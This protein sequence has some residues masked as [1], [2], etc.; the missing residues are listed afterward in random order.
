M[1]TDT[2]LSTLAS[3]SPFINSIQHTTRQFL[4]DLTGT[5][6]EV[7]DYSWAL[8]SL[9][10]REGELGLTD[11]RL[12]AL[13]ALLCPVLQAIR[14]AHL[15]F[16]IRNLQCVPDSEHPAPDGGVTEWIRLPTDLATRFLHWQTSPSPLFQHFTLFIEQYLNLKETAL[17][18]YL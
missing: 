14:V 1:L 17:W 4:R 12:T 13:P 9:P 3:T 6:T 18:S 2:V 7:P 16:P 8:A 10:I 11:F 15:G 5:V